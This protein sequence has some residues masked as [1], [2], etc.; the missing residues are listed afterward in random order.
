MLM[1]LILAKRLR[2]STSFCVPYGTTNNCVVTPL[3]YQDL[4]WGKYEDGVEALDVGVGDEGTQ[5]TEETDGA[6][7]VCGGGGGVLHVHVHRPKQVGH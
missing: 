1:K 5:E 6:E 7:E 4:D 3:N 2:C